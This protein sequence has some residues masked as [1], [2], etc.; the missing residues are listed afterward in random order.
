MWRPLEQLGAALE[1]QTLR[2]AETP[3]AL[4]PLPQPDA[5][6]RHHHRGWRT[7]DLVSLPPL[8]RQPDYLAAIRDRTA[9]DRQFAALQLRRGNGGGPV[10]D[11]VLN[12]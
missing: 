2:T 9:A 3:D 7:P 5:A 10:P 12:Q 4:Q 1:I 8:R 6:D 11:T